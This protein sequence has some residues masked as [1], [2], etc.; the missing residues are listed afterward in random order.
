MKTNKSSRSLVLGALFTMLLVPQAFAAGAMPI[1]LQTAIDK[2][3]ATH[4]DIK[5][6]EYNAGVCPW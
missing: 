6:A 4:P 1:D 2:A 3:F 5:I